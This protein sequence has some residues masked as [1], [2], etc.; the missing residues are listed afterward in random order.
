MSMPKDEQQKE[1]VESWRTYMDSLEKSLD[2]LEKDINEASEMTSVCTDEWCESTEHV[3]DELGNALFTIH[4]PK[5]AEPKDTQRLKS[6]KR[7]VHDLYANYRDVY[8]KAG[9]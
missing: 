1:I 3:I 9:K 2:N 7:R 6:L 4:E 5:F 8:Q